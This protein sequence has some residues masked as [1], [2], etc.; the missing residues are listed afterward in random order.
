VALSAQVHTLWVRSWAL[1]A[2]SQEICIVSQEISAQ[3]QVLCAPSR[4]TVD[5]FPN[6]S[7]PRCR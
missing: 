1:C 7:P 5:S 2:Q 6:S 3:S 4:E